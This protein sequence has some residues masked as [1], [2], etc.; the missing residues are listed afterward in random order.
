MT[1]G[2]SFSIVLLGNFVA[3]LNMLSIA[4]ESQNQVLL[5]TWIHVICG[6]GIIK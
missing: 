1:R 5:D 4:S 2:R 3:I 6:L